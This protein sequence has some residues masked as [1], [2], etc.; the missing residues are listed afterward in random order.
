MKREI[1]FQH[2]KHL[3]GKTELSDPSTKHDE[4]T[5]SSGQPLQIIHTAFL[6]NYT[7]DYF[8]LLFFFQ[9]TKISDKKTK[10][11]CYSSLF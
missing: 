8:C 2:I 3:T 7:K 9:Q 5:P 11:D 1:F 6:R 10:N 4:V